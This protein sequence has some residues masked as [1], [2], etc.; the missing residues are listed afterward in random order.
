M[1]VVPCSFYIKYLGN[2][3]PESRKND[4]MPLRDKLICKYLSFFTDQFHSVEPRAFC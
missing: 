2:M 4:M 3:A 1:K